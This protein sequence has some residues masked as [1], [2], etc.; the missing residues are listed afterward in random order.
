[1]ALQ[2]FME[3]WD[4]AGSYMSFKE[5][6]AIIIQLKFHLSMVEEFKLP[7]ST[8]SLNVFSFSS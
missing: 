4:Q 5:Q 3:C 6:H 8:S 1:M 2:T 7:S